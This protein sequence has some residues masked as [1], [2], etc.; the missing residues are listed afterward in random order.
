MT[1]GK[2]IYKSRTEDELVDALQTI[3]NALWGRRHN[4]HVWSIPVDELRDA[5]C[6]LMDGINELVKLREAKHDG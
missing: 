5:D 6:I 4:G 2:E 3:L 1:T